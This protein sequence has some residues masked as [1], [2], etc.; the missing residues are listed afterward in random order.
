MK[1]TLDNIVFILC[2]CLLYLGGFYTCRQCSM[3]FDDAVCV[4][5]ISIKSALWSELLISPSRKSFKTGRLVQPLRY[6]KSRMSLVGCF[7]HL[8]INS[9]GIFLLVI[10]IQNKIFQLKSVVPIK[11]VASILIVSIVTFQIIDV[12]NNKM[13]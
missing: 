11:V 9:L 5:S 10:T 1:V 8:I 12:F 4:K 13:I 3:F 2:E 6:D 7:A